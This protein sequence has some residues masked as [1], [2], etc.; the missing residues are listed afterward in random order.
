MV[1]TFAKAIGMVLAIP[2]PNRNIGIQDG[3]HYDWFGM[4]GYLDLESLQYLT[5]YHP[6][7][8]SIGAPTVVCEL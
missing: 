8:F 1:G 4:V 6:N 3:S 7:H 5:I 2:K